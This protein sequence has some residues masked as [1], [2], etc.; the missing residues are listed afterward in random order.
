[1]SAIN[2][3]KDGIYDTQVEG[4]LTIKG[5]TKPIKEK[6]TITV[7]N[8]KIKV[9]TRLNIVLA[10]YGITFSSGKPSTNIAK[11]IEVTVEGEYEELES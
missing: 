9:A 6:G 3:E 10:D 4:E 1:M 8:G 2:F 5:I 11:E 7:Q